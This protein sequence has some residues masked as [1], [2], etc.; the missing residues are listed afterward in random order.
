MATARGQ[1][2]QALGARELNSRAHITP[3]KSTRKLENHNQDALKAQKD[4]QQPK[5]K[6]KK[7]REKLSSLCKTPPSLIR[8]RTGKDY[9]RGLFLGEGGFAR[10]FQI[11][12]DSGKVFA[13]KTVAKAS[14]KSDKTKTKLLSE[15]KIHKSMTHPNIVQFVDCF[16]D[17]VNVYILLEICPNQS[18][19]DLLK[20]RKVLTEPEVRFFMTQIIGGIRYMHTRRVIHRDLK[21][22]NIF[23]DPEMNLKIGDFGLAAVL[24]ASN[25]RKY[26]ICGTPNYIA[27]EVLTG[28][29]TGHS[30]EVDIWSIGVMMYALLIGKPPFQSK[31]VS[32]IYERIKRND[33]GF[34]SEK[35]ISKE[36][37]SLIK[38]ILTTNPV[39]RPT[40]DEILEYDFFKGPFPEKI[41]VETLVSQ[42]EFSDLGRSQS[43][44]N[45]LNA[46]RNA[47]LIH[48]SHANPVEILKTDLESE[49]PKALLPQSL[50][51]GNTKSKYK[52]VMDPTLRPKK[53]DDGKLGK[54]RRL[55]DGS[56]RRT[57]AASLSES[58]LQQEC[59]NTLNGISISERQAKMRNLRESDDELR[60]PIL[61]SK[62]VDYSNKHGF[63]YQL[64]TDDI[65]VLFNDGNTLLRI[66][67]TDAF[68]Y[69]INDFTGGWLAQEYSIN[70][71]PHHLSRQVEIT[72]FF[73][74][75]MKTNLCKVSN[76]DDSL[77]EHEEIFL[78]R[79]T[80]DDQFVMFELSNGSFQFN[81][82][83][84]HK[85][86][87]SQT[88]SVITYISPDRSS[89]TCL[90]SSVL[91]NN[92]FPGVAE[93]I[94]LTDKLH[95]IK[96]ALKEKI[97]N[98]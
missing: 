55:E 41:T 11:R 6:A 69:I 59:A 38:D 79:Y 95:L 70:S 28:K 76:D 25:E 65:G 49:K 97:N 92:G 86:C 88:G 48:T 31:D 94:G 56:L 62:W 39:T 46:K 14:I 15:I 50:S 2:L 21:L 44:M 42:P 45:F 67:H 84:H 22:G 54:A 53:Y 68:W 85:I 66:S 24:Q 90:L 4:T 93:D 40:L 73:A 29:T 8:T 87:I 20:K 74:K 60:T 52:E 35:P 33:Y 17:D 82:K 72:E 83:D 61:I 43:Q 18:L 5:D 3:L 26:T 27:P 9:K 58:I 80:R 77:V 57:Q 51:P 23:F 47:G 81:F 12:D 30:Y 7:K 10:C 64:S 63:S 71:A 32:E 13:A 89:E 91:K 37:K 34:P 1:P 19:M 16:E 96:A 98:N 36:A 75:Y 78:R